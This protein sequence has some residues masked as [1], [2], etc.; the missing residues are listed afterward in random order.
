MSFSGHSPRKRFGQ[1]WLKDESILEK[2]IEAAD[3]KSLDRV[4]EIG[5]GRGALTKKLIESSVELIH[6]IELD[7]D[8]VVGLRKR[9]ENESRFT[10]QEGDVLSIS[11]KPPDGKQL[12]KVVANIPYNITSPL[13]GRLIGRLGSPPEM[14]YHRLVL[15]LQKE[16]AQ[17]IVSLPGKSNFS[18]M[19]VRLQLLA[20]CRSVCEVP[21]RCFTP[22]P[23]VYS[24]VIALD[25]LNETERLDYKLEKKIDFLLR[26]AF[27]SRRKKLKNTLIGICPLNK[28]ETIAESQGFSLNER[29]QEISPKLW[30]GLAKGI[31]KL[32]LA[33]NEH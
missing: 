4:L 17:R 9:F 19:S 20:K 8:L 15:L 12:N 7:V 30:V 14:K 32:E 31:E 18:A 6:G 11:L 24:Q 33:E 25:P 13:L 28:L 3:L 16:V 1:H 5:P 29:P 27:S 22:S 2:I 23:K 10:L 26:R 21:P